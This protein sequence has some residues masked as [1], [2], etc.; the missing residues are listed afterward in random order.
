MSLDVDPAAVLSEVAASSFHSSQGPEIQILLLENVSSNAVAFLHARQYTVKLIKT[1]LSKAELVEKIRDVHVIGIRSRTVIDAEV[2]SHAKRLL[3]ICC[4]CIGTDKVDHVEA[5]LRGIPVFNS[6]Y[7]NS[8]S[9][10]ELVICQI[11]SLSRQLGDRNIEMHNRQWNKTTVGCHEIRGKVLGIIGYGHIGCQVSVLAES[12]GMKVI[13]YDIRKVM[14]LGNSKSMP[15]LETLLQTADFVTLHVPET[16]ETKEM[17]TAKEL[18]LMKKGSYLL[19]TSRGQVLRIG[20]LIQHLKSG[21]L[22]GAYLDVYGEE[23]LENGHTDLYA[24]LGTCPNTIM[25]PHIGGSTVEAQDSIGLDVSTK[26]DEYLSKGTTL[27][28]INFPQLELNPASRESHRIMNV[29]HNRPGVLKQINEILSSFNVEAQVL[30]TH[31]RIGYLI[32][33]LDSVVSSEICN[34]IGQLPASIKTRLVY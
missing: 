13:H 2:L 15:L 14:P 9:V 5:M 8:R 25:T 32:A 18:G 27:G 12:L 4:F 19:N 1:S 31:D 26:I 28:A 29:H 17:I 11:I 20:D 21:H 33:D 23:P 30:S 34:L 24:E 10:A 16:P 22:A 6:P 7:E 3:A